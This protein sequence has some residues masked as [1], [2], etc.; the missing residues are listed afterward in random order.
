MILDCGF[1]D[2]VWVRL[3]TL[4][5]LFCGGA[6]PATGLCEKRGATWLAHRPL[7]APY[8]QA[9]PMKGPACAVKVKA[10]PLTGMD[11][12]CVLTMVIQLHDAQCARDQTQLRPQPPLTGKSY[13]LGTDP[14][15]VGRSSSMCAIVI[16]GTQV[17]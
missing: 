1:W 16:P 17:C 12:P 4:R 2:V 5:S 15:T 13:L 8:L 6:T 14:V 10:G 3:I 11:P 7:T 9:Q